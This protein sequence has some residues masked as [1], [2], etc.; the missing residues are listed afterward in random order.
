MFANSRTHSH[1]PTPNVHFHFS[2]FFRLHLIHNHRTATPPRS[3][4]PSPEDPAPL[5]DFAPTNVGDASETETSATALFTGRFATDSMSV[6]PLADRSPDPDRAPEGQERNEQLSG[7]SRDVMDLR[8]ISDV[9]GHHAT[10]LLGSGDRLRA[11]GDAQAAVVR[12]SSSG[13]TV[14]PLI[15]EA[16]G[17]DPEET[18]HLSGM[19]MSNK[20]AGI[21]WSVPRVYVG[22]FY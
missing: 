2:R 16:A 8:D 13:E 14:P 5:A 18:S 20:H 19:P 11:N 17:D 4:S 6:V 3:P 21:F 7:G 10:R 9:D 22:F 15:P 12:K 1:S